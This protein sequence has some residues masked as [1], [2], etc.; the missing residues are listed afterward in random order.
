MAVVDDIWT[1][2]PRGHKPRP[3][4]SHLFCSRC[5]AGD[6][7]HGPTGCCQPVTREPNDWACACGTF[8]PL[9]WREQ[10]EAAD[11]T[12][13]HLWASE[14]GRWRDEGCS[15]D[16]DINLSRLRVGAMLDS[17]GPRRETEEGS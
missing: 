1:N 3:R 7:V 8:R 17:G 10:I 15:T 4:T 12:Q 9:D 5:L 13:P 6:H 14:R 16:S 2:S 11:W